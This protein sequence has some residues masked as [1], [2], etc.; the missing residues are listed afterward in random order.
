MQKTNKLTIGTRGSAL[1]LI[2]ASI[3]EE[4]IIALDKN[5]EVE[6]KIIKTEGDKNSKPI[7]LSIIGKSW[8]TKEIE[9]ELTEGSIDLAVHSLKDLPNILYDGLSI[10]A[11]LEREEAEDVLITKSGKNL[12]D[13][14]QR[15]VI[16]TDSVRRKVQLLN[17][18][19]DL[20]IISIRGNVPTRIAKLFDG[21]E[22][23][24][25][26]LAKAGLVRLNLQ[27][28]ITQEF[29]IELFTPAPGQGI[30][31]IETKVEGYAAEIAKLLND[32]ITELIAS[33][34]R[35]FSIAVDGGCKKPV[36]AHAKINKNNILTLVGMI[37]KE[38]T[39]EI[40][41]ES[42]TG[43]ATLA[44]QLGKDLAERIAKK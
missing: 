42:I 8:F 2:Q 43:P 25:I 40:I 29:S 37:T 19:P 41:K 24:G 22:Y 44:Q 16:G 23:E 35:S 31:A 14:P 20:N 5:I 32:P 13:L 27:S 34:E 17:L 9:K 15:A 26:V 11:Y 12:Q 1:A 7:P 6:T 21:N 33:A 38:N 3:I 4:K 36:G 39:S 18:R 30:L 10:T 28:K